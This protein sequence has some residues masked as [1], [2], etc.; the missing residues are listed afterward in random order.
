MATSIPR[1]RGFS[2]PFLLMV[3]NSLKTTSKTPMTSINSHWLLRAS[4]PRQQLNSISSMRTLLQK[5]SETPAPK[6]PVASRP[7]AEQVQAKARLG[8]AQRLAMKGK[9]TTLYE[10]P[11]QGAFLFS[12]YFTALSCFAGAVVNS[13]LNVQNLPEGMSPW[14]GVG[15]TFISL[16]FAVLGTTFALRPAGII[17]GIKLLPS[18]GPTQPVMLEVAVRRQLPLPLPLHRMRVAPEQFVMLNR[19]CMRPPA[20]QTEE[21]KVALRIEEAKK[22]KEDREYELNHLM[23][24]PFRDA[25]KAGFTLME[26]IQRGLT[27]EGFAPIYIKGVMYKVDVLGGYALEGGLVL[28]RIVR[29]TGDAKMAQLQ[30]K[31]AAGPA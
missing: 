14:V 9:P 15:Y 10:G 7:V 20:V 5:Q 22:R 11:P 1:C 6:P 27:G 4:I 24:A 29:V 31:E 3:R 16:M 8:F 23:T 26:N 30:S 12:S 2:H 17:R 28:D 13:H 21:E 18:S 19:M 25:R